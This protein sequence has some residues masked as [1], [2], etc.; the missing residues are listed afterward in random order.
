VINNFVSPAIASS[1]STAAALWFGVFV[2]GGS[3]LTAALLYPIDKRAEKAIKKSKGGTIDSDLGAGL[4]D[5]DG[6]GNRIKARSADNTLDIRAVS[7]ERLSSAALSMS[8][9]KEDGEN[10]EEEI[11]I[12]DAFKFGNIFWLLSLSCLVV[13]GCVLPF[14]NV[15][16]GILLEVRE[17]GR[18]EKRQQT[19]IY[20]I[21]T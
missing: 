12:S 14:N 6:E 1:G 16:G 20:R 19:L 3:L 15:A 5:N 13:Y 21:S 10:V 9:T 2:C 4:L 17:I 7:S 18:G 11:N 8:Q